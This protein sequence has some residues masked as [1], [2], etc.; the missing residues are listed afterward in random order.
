MQADELR[1][2]TDTAIWAFTALEA[3]TVGISGSTATLL[4]TSL[5]GIQRMLARDVAPRWRQQYY[6]LGLAQSQ[7]CWQAGQKHNSSL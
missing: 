2:L 6:G 4:R 7:V 5:M 3:G 1:R